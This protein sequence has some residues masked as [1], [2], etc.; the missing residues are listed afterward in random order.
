MKVYRRTHRSVQFVLS[1]GTTMKSSTQ[2]ILGVAIVAGSLSSLAANPLW[3]QTHL[4]ASDRAC[5]RTCLKTLLDT[6]V[7]ALTTHDPSL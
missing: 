7:T 2:L 1:K 5:D 4:P 3:A 6:Y